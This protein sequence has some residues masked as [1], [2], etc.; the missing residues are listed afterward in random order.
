MNMI[1]KLSEINTIVHGWRVGKD[2][3]VSSV[4]IDTRTLEA[5]D[6]YVAI[7]G[8][9]FDGNDFVD[10][11]DMAG[12]AA[13]I[14]HQ[15]VETKLPHIVVANTRKALADLACAWRKKAGIS[16]VGITGSNG[17]TTVKEMTASI[18][19]SNARVLHTKGNLNNDI[20][21]PLT[22]LRLNSDHQYAVVEM[23]ANHPGEIGYLGR[24]AKPDISII[25]NV[26]PAHIEGFGD[27]DGV[28][29]EKGQIVE[30][31]GPE[32][33]AVL[34]ADDHYFDYW[35]KLAGNR[36]VIPFGMSERA[37]VTASKIRSGIKDNRFVTE[38]SLGISGD[39]I[40]IRMALAGKHNVVN[41]LAAAAAC[42]AL[43][44]DLQQIK[45]GLEAILPVTGRLQPLM[46][47]QGSVV[48]D[49]TYNANPASLEA[50]LEVLVS[51]EGEPW[52][53]LGAFGEMGKDSGKIHEELG[54]LIKSKGVV[55]VLATGPDAAN[56]VR[57]FGKGAVFFDTQKELIDALNRE[58]KGNETI[59]IKGSRSQRME[60]IAEAL[61][62][63]FRT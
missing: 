57:V 24:C 50:A 14:L 11:A 17:K 19:G 41:A 52:V 20:G 54:E 22:L 55:R 1:M 48:I 9:N 33:V 43:D 46:S 39:E 3:E 60:K 10:K 36:T 37:E 7:K 38:F 62:E 28:A 47:R 18:L 26:G 29:R 42:K 35:K 56:T 49:D 16:V 45:Q 8:E 61:V 58:L 25:T 13:A 31:L 6:L 4:S 40:K 21:V 12:A 44:I 53:V 32:G 34:N 30:S 59:L 27:I 51:C 5:G 2:M 15:E 63:G 23:G